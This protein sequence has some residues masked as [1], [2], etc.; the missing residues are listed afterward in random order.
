MKKFRKILS[1]LTAAAIMLTPLSLSAQEQKIASALSYE[2]AVKIAVSS[3]DML[4]KIKNEAD[5]ASNQRN[6]LS[7]NFPPEASTTA[8]YISTMVQ[9]TAD[10]EALVRNKGLEYDSTLDAIEMQLKNIFFTVHLHEENM[11]IND[12]QIAHLRQSVSIEMQKKQYG[13]ASD[14]SVKKMQNDLD[15]LIKEKAVAEKEVQKHY[16]ALN[17]L[18]GQSTVKYTSLK[19]LALE[20]RGVDAKDSEQKIG[21]ALANSATVNY[22]KAHIASLE[23]KKHLYPFNTETAYLL[24]TPA[25]EKPERISD[26]IAIASDDLTVQKRNLEDQIR[27]LYN[28]LKSMEATITA[29]QAQE[30]ILKER[31]RIAEVQRKAGMITQQQV[32][33]AKLQLEL[34]AHGIESLKGQHTLLKLQFDKPHLMQ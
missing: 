24:G 6:S 17:K 25:P 27:N 15:K 31:I 28:S 16:F 13:M 7:S 3:N 19:P 1:L 12:R 34:L 21:V 18:L 4:R 9:S 23:L 2:E 20:Y 8:P 14:F 32:D 5:S 26:E 30:K 33:E 11:K 10:L 29:Q 22:K